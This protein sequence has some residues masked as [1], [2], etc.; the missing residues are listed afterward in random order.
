M[1][2]IISITVSRNEADLLETF[3]RHHLES[4]D[5][6]I[7][8]LL[9]SL[10]NSLEIL[11][12]LIAEGLP[13]ELRNSDAHTY[14][15]SEIHNAMTA[16]LCS[17][18]HDAWILPLDADEFLMTRQGGSVREAILSSPI[19]KPSLM[20]WKSYVPRPNDSLDEA[21]ILRRV[22]HRRSKEPY[23]YGKILLHAG[24]LRSGQFMIPIGAH[25][26]IDRRSGAPIVCE[27]NPTLAIGHFPVRSAEQIAIKAFG[28]WPR[29]REMPHRPEGGAYQWKELYDRC[30]NPE[31]ISPEELESIGLSYAVPQ[32]HFTPK[33]LI[34]DAVP[35]KAGSLRYPYILATPHAV[36]T[37]AEESLRNEWPKLESAKEHP[38][39]GS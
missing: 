31:P 38:A 21:C 16:E 34:D 17:T 18:P 36:L 9:R 3:V 13:I 14:N 32:G 8:V 11:Q 7:I 22:R 26:L 10:D 20:L 37:D 33:D 15:Q 39:R 2:Q 24:L 6:I 23:P 29:F 5:R 28:G 12:Q 19:S 27:E 4:V 25:T 35:T 1:Q 30:T